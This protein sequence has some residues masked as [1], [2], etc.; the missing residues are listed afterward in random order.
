MQKLSAIGR[1]IRCGTRKTC[2]ATRTAAQRQ[3]HPGGQDEDEAN[4]M[5]QLWVLQ[6]DGR[7]GVQALHLQH[8]DHDRCD[9]ATE[10]KY[11]CRPGSQAVV[12]AHAPE[13][14]L[15]AGL[16]TE[17]FIAWIIVSKFGD[18]LPFY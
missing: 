9:A 18:Q 7:A 15:P 2:V 11:A 12:Q 4:R 3:E 6:E 1:R 14:V 8:A 5:D 13:H 10:P 16:L 17:L